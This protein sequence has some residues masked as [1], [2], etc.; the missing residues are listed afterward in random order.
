MNAQS[1]SP[2]TKLCA[3]INND[4]CTNI[5]NLKKVFTCKA[6]SIP[7]F[8]PYLPQV[9]VIFYLIPVSTEQPSTADSLSWMSI[10]V[11][12]A[13]SFVYVFFPTAPS[14]LIVIGTDFF[15]LQSWSKS[16]RNNFSEH[17]QALC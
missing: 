4:G 16:S 9:S 3:K 14:L 6:H 15:P 13:F 7:S 2:K 10:S 17:S 11:I 1:L 12:R 8:P 5:L